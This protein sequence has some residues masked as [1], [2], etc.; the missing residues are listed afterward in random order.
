MT[1]VPP[2]EEGEFDDFWARADSDAE[3]EEQHEVGFCQNIVCEVDGVDVLCNEP[4]N[5]AEQLCHYCRM[6]ITR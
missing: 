4:C 3:E 6:G 5:P 1:Q 2:E